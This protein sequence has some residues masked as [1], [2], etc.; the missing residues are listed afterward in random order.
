MA[1]T[2]SCEE[3]NLIGGEGGYWQCFVTYDNGAGRFIRRQPFNS[4]TKSGLDKAASDWLNNRP[5]PA[6]DLTNV[7][8]PFVV[9]L[10]PPTTIPVVSQYMAK[11]GELSACRTR[12]ANLVAIGVPTTKEDDKQA[13]LKTEI[14][15]L[16]SQMTVI[17]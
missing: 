2:A 12:I 15:A 7:D 3:K 4:G 16:L 17:P 10:A 5:N 1:W 9:I 6:D 11:Q 8:A 14:V 13:S